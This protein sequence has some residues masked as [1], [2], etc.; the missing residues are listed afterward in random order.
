MGFIWNPMWK[1]EDIFSWRK[2]SISISL[3]KWVPRERHRKHELIPQTRRLH[4]IQVYVSLS[5]KF[6]VGE[7]YVS[8]KPCQHDSASVLDTKWVFKHV[9]V[10]VTLIR[11]LIVTLWLSWSTFCF[12]TF[13]PLP[14]SSGEAKPGAWKCPRLSIREHTHLH[15]WVQGAA[16]SPVD[17]VVHS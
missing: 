3:L 11:R 13:G 7:K 8:R 1:I 15:T 16:T 14:F 5:V 4:F 6:L 2:C 17:T 9:S 10:D 12:G